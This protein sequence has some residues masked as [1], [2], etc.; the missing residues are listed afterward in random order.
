[1]YPEAGYWR[2]MELE[3]MWGKQGLLSLGG[4]QEN[5]GYN[6]KCPEDEVVGERQLKEE[7]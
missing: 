4:S 5:E 2:I 1:M 7:H 3:G 6:E